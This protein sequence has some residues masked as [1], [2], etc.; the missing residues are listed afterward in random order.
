[1]KKNNEKTSELI[2]KI[3]GT[4]FIL[5]PFSLIFSM[6]FS[7]WIVGIYLGVP[8]ILTVIIIPI[9]CVINIWTEK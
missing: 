3:V 5:F 9:I 8:I 1:M 2:M 4:Y 7:P 6:I